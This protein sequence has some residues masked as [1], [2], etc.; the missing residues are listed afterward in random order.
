MLSD[1]L[2]IVH[3]L[4]KK[5]TLFNLCY[6]VMMKS[7]SI[8]SHHVFS[9]HNAFHKQGYQVSMVYIMCIMIHDKNEEE[10][11][12]LRIFEMI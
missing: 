7:D 10:F 11:L 2:A 4:N 12:C 8:S 5:Y 1:H 9:N 3:C 6:L